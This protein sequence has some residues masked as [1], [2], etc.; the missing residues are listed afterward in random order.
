MRKSNELQIGKAGEYL[1]CADLIMKGMIAFPSEQGLPYDILIDTG[2][3]LLRCQVKTTERPR[4]VPQRASEGFAYIFNIKRHGK[5]SRA[6]YGKDE[7]DL[8]ALV[9][10]EN[11]SVVYILNRDLPETI[12]IRCDHLKGTHRDERGIKAHAKIMEMKALGLTQTEIAKQM[13][14]S[15]SAVNRMCQKDYTPHKTNARYWSDYKRGRE[16]FDAI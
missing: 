14:L 2:K 15:V 13:G 9:E 12:N 16:W 5:Q 7:V 10:L 4:K 11:R 8:F 6:R 3:K 1:V